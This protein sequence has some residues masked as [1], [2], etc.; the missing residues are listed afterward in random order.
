MEFLGWMAYG[1]VSACA[2]TMLIGWLF[3]LLERL[4][5]VRPDVV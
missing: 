2:D 1:P 5:G 3:D 4:L